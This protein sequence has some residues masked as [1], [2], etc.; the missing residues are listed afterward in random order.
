MEGPGKI[1]MDKK[2]GLYKPCLF[3]LS[4]G[5]WAADKPRPGQAW[6]SPRKHPQHKVEHKKGSDDDEGDEV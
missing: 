6:Y 4:I 1:L 3:V 5:I 2:E